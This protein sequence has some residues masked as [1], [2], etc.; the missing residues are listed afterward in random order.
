M[1]LFSER[2]GYR[3]QKKLTYNISN[4]MYDVILHNCIRYKEYLTHIFQ[5]ES[6][7]FF[8]GEKFVSFN[9]TLFASKMKILIP[10]LFRNEYNNIAVPEEGVFL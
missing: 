4:S 5:L 6:T 7:D 8:L 1:P 3:Q 9:D 10:S 2:Y